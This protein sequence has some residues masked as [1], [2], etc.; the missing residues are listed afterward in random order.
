MGKKKKDVSINIYSA[1]LLKSP[2]P[3]SFL[4]LLLEK[5]KIGEAIY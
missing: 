3:P 1:V 2:E 5:W 4:D